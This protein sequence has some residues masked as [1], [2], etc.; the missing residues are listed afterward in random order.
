MV[1]VDFADSDFLEFSFISSL[2]YAYSN[3][4]SSTNH[5]VVA[6]TDQTH[7]LNVSRYGRRSS[8]LCIRVHT[9]H[10]IC[11]TIRS[12]TCCHVIW[13]KCTSCTT[14]GC[15]G[16]VLLTLLDT[17]LL[18]CTCNRMLETCWVCRVTSDGNT[19]VLMMHDCNTFLNIISTVT[20]Y[21]CA[22]SVRVCFLIYD[23]K[24]CSLVIILCLYECKSV[25]TG[26][27]LCCVFSKTV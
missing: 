16:E 27:D 23:V 5:R 18:V 14:A 13:V 1:V 22:K 3:S 7:H 17:F 11:H 20:F 2:L 12:R 6:H 26:N 4:N 15:Y 24:L 9:S 10:S 8:E 19:Y 25:D 21:S